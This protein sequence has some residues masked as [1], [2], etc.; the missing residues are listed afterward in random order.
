MS[1][2]LKHQEDIFTVCTN[3]YVMRNVVKDLDMFWTKFTM[4]LF[5]KHCV[6]QCGVV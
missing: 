6:I 5:Y 4:I 2:L 3:N 1:D